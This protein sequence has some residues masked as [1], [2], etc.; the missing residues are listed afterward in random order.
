MRLRRV[1]H[2]RALRRHPSSSSST[3]AS[4]FFFLSPQTPLYTAPFPGGGS[5]RLW[6]RRCQGSGGRRE[7]FQQF[8]LLRTR[9]FLRLRQREG[10]QGFKRGPPPHDGVHEV[11]VPRVL[12]LHHVVE[13]F[14]QQAHVHVVVLRAVQEAV[15]RKELEQTHELHGAQKAQLLRVRAHVADDGQEAVVQGGELVDAVHHEFVQHQHQQVGVRAGE[16]GEL[17]ARQIDLERLV[18][19]HA[20]VPFSRQL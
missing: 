3:T 13:D 20:K 8:R 7:P 6:R 11:R 12:V 1:H 14:Q 9:V 18:Q 16:E 4:A 10:G 17:V 2:L 19:L 5:W 15:A